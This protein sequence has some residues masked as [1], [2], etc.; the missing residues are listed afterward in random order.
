MP[1]VRRLAIAA[2]KEANNHN[3]ALHGSLY[4]TVGAVATLIVALVSGLVGVILLLLR[5]A[6][7]LA[8]GR[9]AHEGSEQ[10]NRAIT[11]ASLDEVIVIDRSG[12]I[13][14][15]SQTS[16]EVFGFPRAKMLG[17]SI[18]EWLVPDRFA[19]RLKTILA[20]AD[21]DIPAGRR[22]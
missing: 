22:L 6:S 16:V 4:T 14:E 10:F 5:Q 11:R 19:G 18:Y 12:M 17:G 2:L 21:S 9:Q 1:S 20:S 13:I 7:A 3:S 15:Y 8:Q